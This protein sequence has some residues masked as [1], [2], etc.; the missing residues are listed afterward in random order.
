[1]IR[2]A[3]RGKNTNFEGSAE[4]L[5]SRRRMRHCLPIRL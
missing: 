5:Q 2:S 3:M 1:L 4:T